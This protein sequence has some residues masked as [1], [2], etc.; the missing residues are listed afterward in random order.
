[1]MLY[2]IEVL[3][4]LGAVD[5]DQPNGKICAPGDTFTTDDV[6]WIKARRHWHYLT[7]EEVTDAPAPTPVP[8]K[9]G[10]G[11]K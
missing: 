9:T 5:V 10:K 8:K 11:K 3:K 4:K 7:I 6:D 2:R 1:M